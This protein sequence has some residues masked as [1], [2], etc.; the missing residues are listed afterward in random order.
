MNDQFPP[1]DWFMRPETWPYWMPNSLTGARTLPAPLKTFKFP[2]RSRRVAE[3]SGISRDPLMRRRPILGQRRRRLGR[4]HPRRGRAFRRRVGVR[5]AHTCLRQ[6]LFPISCP[7]SPGRHCTAR[8]TFSCL[9][10]SRNRHRRRRIFGHG[11]MRPFPTRTCATTQAHICT[12]RC[13]SCT[14][15][16]SCCQVRARYSQPRTRPLLVKRQRPAIMARLQLTWVWVRSMPRSI[17]FRP[18]SSRSSPG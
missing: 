11:C 16:L 3:F 12:S 13:G 9:P 1:P 6:L 14:R 8:A 18:Q 4:C 2:R 15:S 5:R 17:G 10:P 7:S